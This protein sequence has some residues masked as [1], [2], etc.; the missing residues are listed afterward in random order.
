M[1]TLVTHVGLVVGTLAVAAAVALGI[2]S[3]MGRVVIVGWFAV[4]AALAAVGAFAG[5]PHTRVPPVAFA[6][7][8]PI[9]I[10]VWLDARS[11]R[12]RRMV[13]GVALSRLVGVQLYRVFGFLFVVA[14]AQGRMPWEFA[15]PAGIGDL[16]VGLAAPVVAYGLV[17]QTGWSRRAAV[18]W[19]WVGIA[20]LV[21][22]V[23]TGVLTS[24]S[25]FQ[26]LALGSPNEAI[27]RFPFVLVP[28]FLVPVSILLHIFALRRLGTRRLQGP[29]GEDLRVRAAI[30]GGLT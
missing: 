2:R 20:D 28:T 21:V 27:T 26:Q 4:V 18:V 5:Y 13:D 11:P 23:G 15:L 30:S 1:S 14:F 6:L 7:V 19:N 29:A 12:F 9:V 17:R 8:I 3:A 24:P 22:A 10:G 25:V 16:A